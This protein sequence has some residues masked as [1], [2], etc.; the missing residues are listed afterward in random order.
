MPFEELRMDT[1]FPVQPPPTWV[2]SAMGVVSMESA[3]VA[4]RVMVAAISTVVPLAVTRTLPVYVP[5]CSEP[6]VAVT[7]R[8]AGIAV[9]VDETCSQ[10]L[11][12]VTAAVKE[13]G[14]D[15]LRFTVVC[16][17]AAPALHG[18]DSDCRSALKVKPVVPP[19]V[20]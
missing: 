11:P 8:G 7:M 19:T 15:A 4:V 20:A 2:V 10:L 9:A 5:G 14:V 18:N 17:A 1:F 13:V 16:A 3:A 12:E 6:G